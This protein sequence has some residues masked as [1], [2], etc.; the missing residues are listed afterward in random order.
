MFERDGFVEVFRTDDSQI[1]VASFLEHGP[2]RASS[3]VTDHLS[4]GQG[5]TVRVAVIDGWSGKEVVGA[6]RSRRR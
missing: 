4:T 3:R 6:R 2:G 1:G 5:V